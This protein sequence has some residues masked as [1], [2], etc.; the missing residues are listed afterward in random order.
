MSRRCS[1]C[2]EVGHNISNCPDMDSYIDIINTFTSAEEAY[3]VMITFPKNVIQR[4]IML[5]NIGTHQIQRPSKEELIE[6]IIRFKFPDIHIIEDDDD[7]ETVEINQT[8]NETEDVS[9][10]ILDYLS[11]LM[12]PVAT[13]TY[14]LNPCVDEDN[15]SDIPVAEASRIEE[16][17]YE[18]P[19]ATFVQV[20]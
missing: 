15:S 3:N 16:F 8:R 17:N 1:C 2:R 6:I 14:V 11:L 10:L 12:T 18:L 4:Y 7:E 20:L 9:N 5:N 13:A 19:M